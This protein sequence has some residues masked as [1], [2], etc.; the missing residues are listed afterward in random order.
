[1]EEA[2][3]AELRKMEATC[4]ERIDM[5][6]A[7]VDEVRKADLEQVEELSGKLEAA[8]LAQAKL[9]EEMEAMR[10]SLLTDCSR[11]R[12]ERDAAVGRLLASEARTREFEEN[13]GM[14][15]E[16]LQDMYFRTWKQGNLSW[17]D[18]YPRVMAKI[19]LRALEEAK[20]DADKDGG[21]AFSMDAV[22]AQFAKEEK[23]AVKEGMRLLAAEEVGVQVEDDDQDSQEAGAGKSLF[24]VSPSTWLLIAN[25]SFL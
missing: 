2:S 16:M 5:A 22:T 13:E 10:G 25:E 3:R 6:I 23:V 4:K 14:M 20:A 12:S 19:Y 9:R 1:M 15:D 21:V 7:T 8:E 18:D 24:L 11:Y 17:M